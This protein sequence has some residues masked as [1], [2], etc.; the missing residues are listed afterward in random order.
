MLYA[1]VPWLEQLQLPF[2]LPFRLLQSHLVLIGI[3]LGGAALFAWYGIDRWKHIL[4]TDQG[5]QHAQQSGKALGKPTGSGLIMVS[6]AAVV[7]LLVMPPSSAMYAF[8]GC[9]LLA[10]IAG[11]AD[12]VD[13][14]AW[15][16]KKKGLVDLAIV[17]LG[18]IALC[19][20]KPVSVWL[21]LLKGE[22]TLQAWMYLPI[23][24][25]VMWVAI[26]ITNCSD[27]VDGLA[28]TLSLISLICLGGFHYIIIGHEEIAGYLLIPHNPEGARWAILIFTCV[29]ALGGYLWHNAEPSRVMMGDAGSRA[30]GLLL[31]AAMLGTGNPFLILI[32]TPIIFLNGGSG[33][34]KLLVLRIAKRLGFKTDKESAG[35][36]IG[37]FH[38]FRFPLHDH[39]RKELKWSNAQ[40]LMRFS[41]LQGILVFL[42]LGIIMKLR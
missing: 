39:C 15:G 22:F 38:K 37:L 34:V 21:P 27:G 24:A 3:G 23:A 19:G 14:E 12:D 41:L 42:M 9:M 8:I 33:L 2:S 10:M 26:N 25:F 31:G 32:V 5:R 13:P 7:L 17:T 16:E 40:V 29:G 11:Y 6:V 35:T 30:I 20:M 28:G 36:F 1:L 4:P 18:A